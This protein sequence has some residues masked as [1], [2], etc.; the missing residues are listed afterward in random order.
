MSWKEHFQSLETASVMLVPLEEKYFS[1]LIQQ[2]AEHPK[3]WE[4]YLYDG[5]DSERYRE[6]LETYLRFKNGGEWLPFVILSKKDHQ[7]I[8]STALI[9]LDEQNRKLEI[10]ATWLIPEYWGTSVNLECKLAL[11][12]FCFETLKT[13]R[14]LIKTDQKNIRSQKAI[15]KI[16]GKFEGILRKEMIR[17]NGTVRNSVYFSII[18]EEWKDAKT[19]LIHL[20]KEKT[21]QPNS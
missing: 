11:L 12:T 3:I 19:H 14:V 9:E 10:G 21:T 7:V 6:I 2:A 16:G 17:E 8:G 18:D 13:V 15:A 4:F 5:A 1:P 20:L